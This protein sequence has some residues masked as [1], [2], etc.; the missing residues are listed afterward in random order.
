M[1]QQNQIPQNMSVKTK[2]RLTDLTGMKPPKKMHRISNWH[3]RQCNT[4]CQAWP[5]WG[6][7]TAMILL[8]HASSTVFFSHL[9][10]SSSRPR[11]L[12]ENTLGGANFVS[13]RPAHGLSSASAL[14]P[15]L[16]AAEE[17]SSIMASETCFSKFLGPKSWMQP[18]K[19][20]TL[21]S[22]IRVRVESDR[23]R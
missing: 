16:S 15:Y 3:Q 6:T 18:V 22:Y 2:Q 14:P 12:L 8:L 11:R 23:C 7:G 10:S 21:G 4:L 19:Y 20:H 13:R 9:V 17:L 5:L 1:Q